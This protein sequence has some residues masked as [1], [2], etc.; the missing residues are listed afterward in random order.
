MHDFISSHGITLLGMGGGAAG[1]ADLISLRGLSASLLA[2][3]PGPEQPVQALT[4]PALCCSLPL[5]EGPVWAVGR[6][7]VTCWLLALGIRK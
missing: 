1:D 3:H 6:A 2:R 4:Q 5:P 7:P